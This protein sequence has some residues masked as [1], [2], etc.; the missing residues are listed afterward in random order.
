MKKI[1]F[2]IDYQNIL[3]N[4]NIPTSISNWNSLSLLGYYHLNKTKLL[5]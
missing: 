4:K 1:V 2:F 3:S 5:K